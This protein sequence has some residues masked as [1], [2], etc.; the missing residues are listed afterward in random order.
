MKLFLVYPNLDPL[1]DI[2]LYKLGACTG[3]FVFVN[4]FKY[5]EF[6][7]GFSPCIIFILGAG[8]VF[9][10][11]FIMIFFFSN[12]IIVQYS[13]VCSSIFNIVPYHIPVQNLFMVMS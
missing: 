8:M 2:T 11:L 1:K 5:E 10:P 3:F 9:S 13:S 7:T 12:T 6:Y 4:W